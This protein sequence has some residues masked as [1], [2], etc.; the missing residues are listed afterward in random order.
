[1]DKKELSIVLGATANMTFALANVLMGI[2]KHLKNRLLI[3]V[4][5]LRKFSSQNQ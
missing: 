2:E 5:V 3:V 1:M 4:F